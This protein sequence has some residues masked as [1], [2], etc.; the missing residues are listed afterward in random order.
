MSL[1][2][3][4]LLICLTLNS[5]KKTMMLYNNTNL[6]NKENAKSIKNRMKMMTMISCEQDPWTK[7]KMMKI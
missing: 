6:K 5:N 2:L 3:I 4:L 7:M 1:A